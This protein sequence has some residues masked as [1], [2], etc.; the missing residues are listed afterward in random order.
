MDG[1]CS[2]TGSSNRVDLVASMTSSTFASS[3]WPHV[4]VEESSDVSDVDFDS[5]SA[6]CDFAGGE[7]VG[8]IS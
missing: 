7:R 8:W 3:D 5:W 4:G 1:E 6:S 2:S